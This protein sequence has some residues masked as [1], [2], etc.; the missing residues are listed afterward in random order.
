MTEVLECGSSF[1]LATET[2][3]AKSGPNENCTGGPK[4]TIPLAKSGPGVAL[5]HYTSVCG[6]TFMTALCHDGEF[7]AIHVYHQRDE[8][9]AARMD[10]LLVQGPD[11]WLSA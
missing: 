11:E 2:C 4:S 5:Y 8:S 1:D 9:T 6:I 7:I 3:H 10:H